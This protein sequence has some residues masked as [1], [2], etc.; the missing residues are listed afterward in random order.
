M[1]KNYDV[2]IQAVILRIPM[3]NNG[4]EFSKYYDSNPSA[5]EL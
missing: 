1:E 4:E 5:K 3:L 2:S